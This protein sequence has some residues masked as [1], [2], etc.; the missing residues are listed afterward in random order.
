[1]PNYDFTCQECE[2]EFTENVPIAD[3]DAPRKCPN[4]GKKNVK[5]GVSAV[6]VSYSGFKDPISRAGNGWNDMLKKVKKASGKENS[7]RTR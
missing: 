5:R 3:R 7:I 1:M 2:H 6:Q 4:C